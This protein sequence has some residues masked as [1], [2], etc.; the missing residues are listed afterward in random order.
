VQR[1][2]S[3]QFQQ[4]LYELSLFT[5]QRNDVVKKFINEPIQSTLLGFSKVTNA[6]RDRLK[7]TDNNALQSQAQAQAV[8]STSEEK[9]SFNSKL[10][11]HLSASA[12][13][14]DKNAFKHNVEMMRNISANTP[15]SDDMSELLDSMTTENIHMAM[16]TDGFEMVTRVDL[17]PMPLVERGAP[18]STINVQYDKEGRIVNSEFILNTIFHGGIEAE[19]RNEIWKF[20][21]KFYN[22]NSTSKTREETRRQREE[23]Y[24]RM[25]LQWMSMNDDQKSR[26]SLMKERESLIGRL[27]NIINNNNNKIKSFSFIR[28]RRSANRPYKS[29][30]RRRR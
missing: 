26:F 10:S 18:L 21:L 20:L 12:S 30:F 2:N 5:E 15:S 8:T 23:D 11:S 16:N 19:L 4:S 17:G 27:V 14:L 22:W 7:P 29:V 1:Q 3:E 9:S 25:K 28:Q 13:T 24:F 6:I